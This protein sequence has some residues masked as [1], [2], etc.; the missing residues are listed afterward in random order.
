[1]TPSTGRELWHL[2]IVV[3]P[4]GHAITGSGGALNCRGAGCVHRGGTVSFLA[5][6]LQGHD[7]S[8]G[9]DGLATTFAFASPGGKEATV[10]PSLSALCLAA[11]QGCP[12]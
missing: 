4:A 9:G 7:L 8:R 5:I 12:C 11:P 10:Y 3:V 2:C 6:V 1:M